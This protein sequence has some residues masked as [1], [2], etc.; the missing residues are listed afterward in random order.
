MYVRTENLVLMWPGRMMN[1]A[2][3]S[4]ISQAREESF[5]SLSQRHGSRLVPTPAETWTTGMRV[6]VRERLGRG[7]MCAG[8][9]PRQLA[10]RGAVSFVISRGCLVDDCFTWRKPSRMFEVQ[11]PYV[12]VQV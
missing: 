8:K 10:P 12:T 3:F 1:N 2:R 11:V 6:A 4:R 7:V 5:L 9:I